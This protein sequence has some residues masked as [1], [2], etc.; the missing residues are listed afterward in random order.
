MFG[1]LDGLGTRLLAR[2]SASWTTLYSSY[3][4]FNVLGNEVTHHSDGEGIVKL[5][6]THTDEG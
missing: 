5:L 4:G 3:A 1:T 2:Y 6:G